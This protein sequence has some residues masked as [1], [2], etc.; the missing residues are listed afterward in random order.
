M[1][2]SGQ[3]DATIAIN[4][5]QTHGGTNIA[6]G[7]GK[8]IRVLE[9]RRQRNPIA[10][11]IL[12]SDGKAVL[13]STFS[14]ISTNNNNNSGDSASQQAFPVHTFGFGRDHDATILH[15]ISDSSGGTF[16][17]I[18][19]VGLVQDAFARCIGGL[20]SVVAREVQLTVR[21]VSTGVQ[22]GSI[23]SGRY[24]NE[25]SDEGKRGRIEVGNLYAEEE[26]TFLVYVS[27]PALSAGE[28]EETEEK[29]ETTSL[30]DI[31]CQYK[32]AASEDLV[33]VEGARAE[34]QRPASSSP[35]DAM[36][37]LDVDR[38][39]NRIL[40]AEGI[41]EAQQLADRGD[42]EGAKALLEA[43]RSTLL[44]SRSA[45]VGDDV[46]NW[47]EA[48]LRETKERMETMDQYQHTGRAYILSG[49][50]SHLMQRATTRGDSLT[51]TFVWNGDERDLN[52]SRTIGYD[53]PSMV[54][55]VRMSHNL[56]PAIV[57]HSRH[58]SDV[59][60]Y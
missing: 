25:I 14:S 45:A 22:I 18:E 5:L 48:E 37:S 27:I 51:Q 54:S 4:S 56:N 52:A 47:L 40:V 38:Q 39:R 46:C 7:L 10:S 34:I 19:S 15:T 11:I 23:C 36:V 60:G 8:G 44:S 21:A 26:K 57:S 43:R 12:L 20:L 13:P 49:L 59:A 17:F 58:S 29:K 3:S 55:M 28:G 24:A 33:Q 30:L 35:S 53:T 32:K 31:S 42:L 41:A 6:D 1:T 16:S 9:E 50:S 2:D